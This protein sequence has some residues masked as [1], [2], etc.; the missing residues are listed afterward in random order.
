MASCWIVK[1]RY[2][3][4]TLGRDVRMWAY[5]HIIFSVNSGANGALKI[6]GNHDFLLPRPAPI[7]AF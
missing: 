2:I 6:S 5:R 3:P 7:P 1:K 4:S